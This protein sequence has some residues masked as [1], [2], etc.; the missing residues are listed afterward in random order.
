MLHNGEGQKKT[1]GLILEVLNQ[2]CF[3][4]PSRWKRQVRVIL[5]AHAL[6]PSDIWPGR[7]SILERTFV[8]A[9]GSL[10]FCQSLG[11]KY[12]DTCRCLSLQNS[13]HASVETAAVGCG[14]LIHLVVRGN[15][16]ETSGSAANRKDSSLTFYLCCVFCCCCIVATKVVHG[17]VFFVWDWITYEENYKHA[18]CVTNV[19]ACVYL[20]VCAIGRSLGGGHSSVP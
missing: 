15:S 18:A 12:K 20:C 9:R 8:D 14:I 13:T 16:H 7:V 6:L 11:S 1:V 10:V 3:L 2:I 5:R 19:C 4:P 17:K